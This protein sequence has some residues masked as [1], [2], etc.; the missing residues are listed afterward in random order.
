[1][2]QYIEKMEDL[3]GYY[4]LAGRTDKRTRKDRATQPMDHGRLMLVAVVVVIVIAVV[5]VVVDFVVDVVVD[6]VV[7]AVVVVGV[8]VVIVISIHDIFNVFFNH[9]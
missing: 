2:P 1:M 9:N 4:H 8:V 5:V 7:V 6:V 3:V